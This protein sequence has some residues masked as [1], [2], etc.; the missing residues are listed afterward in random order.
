MVSGVGSEGGVSAAA[1]RPSSEGFGHTVASVIKCTRCGHGSLS[2]YPDP[3][4]VSTAYQDAADPVSV[5]EEAGQ[6][7]TAQRALADVER[8]VRPGRLIDVGSWTGSMLVAAAGRG[9][10]PLGVEPSRWAA[11][12]S[13][14]RGVTV[15]EG[16]FSELDTEPG[17]RLVS[18]CDVLE[19]LEDPGAA[20][21]WAARVLAADGSGVY[22]TVPDAGSAL[23]RAMGR[24]WW[25]VLPMHVQYFHR[26]SLARLLEDR[27][28]HVRSM[29][30][31]A[32]VFSARYYAERLGGYSGA[33]GR[34]SVGALERLGLANRLVAPDF[35]DRVAVIATR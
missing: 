22:L 13:R 19:H 30:S 25:S 17:V 14:Q 28:F 2:A 29:R 4:S 7:E 9:W 10:D 1:F 8:Y 3:R 35:H 24:R 23:A 32:K 31:H 5:R 11:D 33:A 6:V 26:P 15:H 12:R 18:F 34:V 20:L 21:D 27:G 16:Q